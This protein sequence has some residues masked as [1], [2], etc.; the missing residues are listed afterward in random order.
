[1]LIVIIVTLCCVILAWCG[2]KNNVPYTG[3]LLSL[4]LVCIMGLRYDVGIDYPTYKDIYDDPYSVDALFI[5]PIWNIIIGLMRSIGLQSRAFFFLI[6]LVT[7]IGFYKG[8]KAMSPHFYLSLLLL[9]LCGFYFESA[10]LLRQYVAISLLFA[11]FHNF[12]C[13]KIWKFLVWI[14]VAAFFHT[15][16]LFVA[17]LIL[18]SR[19][20]FPVFWL[21]AALVI[22]YLFGDWILNTA[23]ELVMP[24]LKAIGSYQYEIDDFESGA[25]SG[26]LKIF[27]HLV[28]CSVMMLYMKYKRAVPYPFYILLNMVVIGLIIYNVCYLFMPARRLYLYFFPYIIILIPYCLP[29]F[30][31]G[32]RFIVTGIVCSGFLLFLIKLYADVAY[33]FDI[34]FF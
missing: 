19:L 5:E 31:Y 25:N 34:Q 26:L 17:P 3:L 7:F 15:S 1:M 24:S 28:V 30:K 32:S 33:H 18:L 29:W 8:I 12:L 20:R 16:V 27:Y 21:F 9:L 2:K 10:N 11:G 4:L 13:G 22:S 14:A 6:S 23:I